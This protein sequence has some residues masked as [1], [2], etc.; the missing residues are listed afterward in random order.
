MKKF[1]TLCLGLMMGASIFAQESSERLVIYDKANN[2]KGYLAERID[3]V[4]FRRVEGKVQAEISVLEVNEDKI[5]FSVT[6]STNCPAY[7]FA[8]VP[9]TTANMLTTDAAIANYVDKK[10][11]DLYQQDFTAGEIPT[12]ELKPG[13]DYVAFTVGV[14]QYYTLCGVSRADFTTY[15]PQFTGDPTV[16]VTEVDVQKFQYTLKF[17]PSADVAGFAVLAGKK[18]E[19]EE[20]FN[21]M[22]PMFGFANIGDMIKGWGKK[23]EAEGTH[24][25]KEMQPGEEQE[26]YIQAWDKYGVN[27]NH[28]I[29]TLR[30]LTNGGSGEARVEVKLGDYKLSDWDGQRLYGQTV[31]YTPNDQTKK[32]RTVVTLKEQYDEDPTYWEELVKQEAPDPNMA[33]W[34]FYE[35]MENEYQ[36]NPGTPA[37]I[38]AAGVNANDEWGSMNKVEFTPTASNTLNVPYAPNTKSSTINVRSTTLKNFTQEGKMPTIKMNKNPRLTGK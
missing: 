16:T 15:K 9:A 19:L 38:L 37:I 24:T 18:G 7:K 14:D 5:K 23:F 26:V 1:F 35:E 4:M 11:D 36:I 25:W 29:Y 33:Y 10:T 28:Q 3:S 13:T 32:Y 30:T 2:V 17:T 34:W 22:A 8:V 21:Q 12:T 27:A 31:V 6:R 20:Q